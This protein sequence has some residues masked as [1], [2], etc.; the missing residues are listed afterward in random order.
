MTE[1]ENLLRAIRHQNP[2]WVP[3][4]FKIMQTVCFLDPPVVERPI[5]AGTDDWGVKYLFNA[6]AEDGSYPFQGDYVLTDVTK[7]R[8][9]VRFPDVDTMDW[10]D[11]AEGWER[12][13]IDLDAIDRENRL[14]I[15]LV[16]IG[17]F[18]RLY[19]LMG[20]ENALINY[21]AEPEAM[22]E[23]AEAIADYRIALIKKFAQT[24]KLDMIWY[25][26]DWGTQ[27]SLFVSPEIWRQII[28]P[29]TKRIYDC[30]KELGLMVCQHSC[31]R[32][33]PI[34]ADFVS[35][36]PDIW[37]PCQPCNDLAALKKA[38]GDQIC[39]FGGIDS[40]RIGRSDVTLE[41][42]RA[43]VRLRI[44]QLAGV[45]GYIA[46]PSQTTVYKPEIMA[47]MFTEI[48]AYGKYPHVSSADL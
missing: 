22:A 23:L 7:W 20:M 3:N 27:S 42:V 16:R 11:I 17:V 6:A 45:G 33:E 34:F 14:V 31:G 1:K 26:D 21:I 28:M 9:Q 8:E 2:Q 12:K 25:S 13:S 40:Q 5:G 30:A 37:N 35:M 41:E 44:D 19:L 4:A 29:Q 46:A 18:E 48:D 24:V 36:G 38:F 10:S 32:I 43:E 39:F 47:A 15:G